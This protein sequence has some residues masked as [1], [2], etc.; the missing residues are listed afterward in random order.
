M[1]YNLSLDAGFTDQSI[2]KYVV[3]IFFS[4]DLIVIDI[5][6]DQ[7]NSIPIDHS[8]ELNAIPGSL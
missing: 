3:W 8:R 7:Y 4:S 5:I 2:E 6:N 1:L